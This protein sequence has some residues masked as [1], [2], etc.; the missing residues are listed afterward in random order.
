MGMTERISQAV[1]QDRAQVKATPRLG[2]THTA[3]LRGAR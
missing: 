3:E 1:R 2:I